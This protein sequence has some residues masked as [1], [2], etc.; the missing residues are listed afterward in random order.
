[1]TGVEL[2]KVRAR[3][4]A[5]EEVNGSVLQETI[6]GVCTSIETSYE[7]E[8]DADPAKIALIVR[9]ARNACIVGNTVSEGVPI[10]DEFTLNGQS[11]DA[12]A[13]ASTARA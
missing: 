7:I 3:I 1:M 10:G 11:F 5:H 9:N 12:D 4:I 8:S 2:K 13:Y 6:R